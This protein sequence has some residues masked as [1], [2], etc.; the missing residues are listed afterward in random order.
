MQ[1]TYIWSWANDESVHTNTASTLREIVEEVLGF[2]LAH[3]FGQDD[4]TIIDIGDNL[5]ISY[6]CSDDEQLTQTIENEASEVCE[7]LEKFC[8][9]I[10]SSDKFCVKELVANSTEELSSYESVM[11]EREISSIEQHFK[12]VSEQS[13]IYQ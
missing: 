13:E 4:F 11:D 1:K 5:Q 6:S 3:N 7:F 2:H 10:D 9:S 12:F 8:T